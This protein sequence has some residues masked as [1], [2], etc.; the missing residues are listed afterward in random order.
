MTDRSPEKND[1]SI[2]LIVKSE[3]PVIF[4]KNIAIARSKDLS[5]DD[6]IENVVHEFINFLDLNSIDRNLIGELT[7]NFREIMGLVLG[8]VYLNVILKCWPI[9]SERDGLITLDSFK[10]NFIG[11]FIETICAAG[12]SSDDRDFKCVADSRTNVGAGVAAVL[13]GENIDD[14][15]AVFGW[16]LNDLPTIFDK[17]SKLL[18][19]LGADAKESLNNLNP[20]L[21]QVALDF[22]HGFY[23]IEEKRS[24]FDVMKNLQ[25]VQ[26]HFYRFAV[27]ILP[28]LE[29]ACGCQIDLAIVVTMFDSILFN[30]ISERLR[31]L[32]R[33]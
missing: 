2:V 4:E 7:V 12:V 29:M 27:P 26:E 32:E 5:F 10:Y 17:C 19:P 3:L 25:V 31:Q 18:K 24:L 1:S 33:P 15:S 9:S 28:K 6:M 23:L 8:G 21:E 14:L 20:F 16:A 13:A 22:V 30:V 11:A